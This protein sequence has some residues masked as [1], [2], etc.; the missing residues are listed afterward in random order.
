MVET[1]M[2]KPTETSDWRCPKPS[3]ILSHNKLSLH[4]P[5]SLT[6]CLLGGVLIY[7]KKRMDQVNDL[8]SDFQLPEDWI[9]LSKMERAPPSQ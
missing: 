5:S 2:D 6:A 7:K 4:Q 3:Q 9:G 1:H 8:S